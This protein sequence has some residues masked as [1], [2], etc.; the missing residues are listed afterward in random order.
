MEAFR[1]T[2]VVADKALGAANIE[3]RIECNKPMFSIVAFE[4]EIIHQII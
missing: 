2:P 3:F 1:V 4:Y